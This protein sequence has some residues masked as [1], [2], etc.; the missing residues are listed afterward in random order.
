MRVSRSLTIKQM[1][2]VAAVAVVF[3]FIFLVIQLFHFVQQ[4]RYNTATQ[5]ESIARSVRQPLSTAILK[6]NIPEAEAILNAIQPTGIVARADVVL[7]NQFQALRVRFL[8]ERPVPVMV[9]RLFELPVQ[10][11]LPL[12][13]TERPGNPQPLAYLVL[14]ADSWRMYK[15]ILSTLSTLVTTYFLLALILT[16]AITWCINRLIVHP[17]RRIARELN[18][19]DAQDAAGHQLA[20]PRLHHDDEIG[21]L[22]RSYNRNQQ[23]AMRQYDEMNT[24]TTRFPVTSLPNKALLMAMLE[25][26]V[27]GNQTTAVIVVACETLQ[28]A[29]GALN[30]EQRELLLRQL[31]EKMKAQLMPR[32]MLAQVSHYDFAILAHGVREPWQAMSLSQ[33]LMAA[34][35]EP[36]ALENS[37]LRPTASI[38]IAMY[39]GDTSAEQLYRRAVSAALSAR[40]AGKNQIQFFDE[41]QLTE[42][43]QRLTE[44]SD[45]LNALDNQAFAIWLQPQVALKTG[46]V[47]SAE[48]LL[49]QR[50]P[51]GEWA[52]PDDLIERIESSGL[53]V[54]IGNWILEESCRLLAAWQRRGIMMPLSVNISALQLLHDDMVASVMELLHRYHI[55]PGTLIL[56]VTESR[57]IDD[58]DA[59]VAILRPLRHAGVKVALDDFGMGYA[60]L[61]QLHR[62]KSLP[63]D[64]IKID[65]NFINDLPDD[66]CMV[67]A[68]INLAHSLQL[69]VIAEGVENAAQRQWLIDEGVEVAQGYLF[70]RA[71]PPAQFE[72]DFLPASHQA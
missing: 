72:A 5:M 47:V 2:M 53:M 19:L 22:V 42:A 31:A 68:I 8:P 61:R 69:S 6:A 54:H 63:L 51:D 41:Q 27:I 21:M 65:K 35:N 52:L 36:V 50:Q 67:R 29:A 15:F 58:P 55:E 59:A 70:A 44:E 40:R 18:H 38:G 57:R 28:D 17:L 16:V 9:A 1:A 71:L 3:I 37:A 30:D 43:Q 10:I 60:S 49:R 4:S 33:K 48:V 46:E 25:Q 66:S 20:L 13:S 62:M 23:M 14:Q 56:E 11:S 12:Y 24:R 26:S 39:Y 45:L 34:L 7:P 64:V 32:M